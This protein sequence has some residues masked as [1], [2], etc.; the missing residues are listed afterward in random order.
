VSY[1][2]TIEGLIDPTTHATLQDAVDALAKTLRRTP[3]NPDRL[4]AYLWMITAEGA[5]ERVRDFMKRDGEFR[6]R[7]ASR[8]TRYVAVIRQN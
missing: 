1:T 2:L 4:S 6:L 3:V 8:G 5:L 7:F